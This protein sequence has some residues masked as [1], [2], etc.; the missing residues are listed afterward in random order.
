MNTYHQEVTQLRRRVEELECELSVLRRSADSDGLAELM[1]RLDITRGQ[2]RMLRAFATGKVMTRDRIASLCCHD[3][4]ASY[5]LPDSQIKRIRRKLKWLNIRTLY[6]VG[7]AV[8]GEALKV[9]R[10]KMAGDDS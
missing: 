5:R 6:G 4:E 7:Y 1:I 2:A 10:E 3:E 9:L 8:E